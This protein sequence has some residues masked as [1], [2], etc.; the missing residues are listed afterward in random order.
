MRSFG[1]Q[2]LVFVPRE[3]SIELQISRRK[4]MLSQPAK[5]LR[6]LRQRPP[7]FLLALA[8]RVEGVLAGRDPLEARTQSGAAS[9]TPE[10]AQ[11]FLID[12]HYRSAFPCHENWTLTSSR[13]TPG[14]NGPA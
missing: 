2:F 13:H 5:E 8:L 7:G 4:Q 9:G 3:P 6:S 12:I 1:K 14:A 11:D 10:C